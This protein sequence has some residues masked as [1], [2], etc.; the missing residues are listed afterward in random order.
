MNRTNGATVRLNAFARWQDS[1]EREMVK[2][3]KMS[4]ETVEE[5]TMTGLF[6]LFDDCRG[7]LL[8]SFTF[9]LSLPLCL[10]QIYCSST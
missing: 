2:R 8:P 9:A 6:A 4:V 1:H 10:V 5:G 3:L 7:L